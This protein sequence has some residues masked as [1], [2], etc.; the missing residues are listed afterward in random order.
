MTN[1]SIVREPPLEGTRLAFVL[2]EDRLGHYPEFRDFF[3]HSFELDRIGLARPGYLR[4]PSGTVYALIFIGRSGEAFPSGVEIHAVVP[5]LEPLDDA[6]TD[7]DLWAILQWMIA[8]IGGA[9]T[10]EALQATGRLF[11]I[12]AATDQP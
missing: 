8:G 7:R 4:A 11:R 9:W 6:Q 10:V 2:A 12:P 5:A 1:V 3:A